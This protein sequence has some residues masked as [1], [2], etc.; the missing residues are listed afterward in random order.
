M[1]GGGA[2]ISYFVQRSAV[3]DRNEMFPMPELGLH[4]YF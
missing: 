4:Y 3:L 1:P 2:G